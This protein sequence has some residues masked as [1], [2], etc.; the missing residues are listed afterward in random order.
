MSQARIRS[1]LESRLSTWASA[2]NPALQIA[3]ESVPFTPPNSTYIRAFLIPAETES[4][5]LRGLHRGMLG[6]FQI[7][8]VAQEGSGAGH[9]EGIAGEIADLF[10]CDLHL[11]MSPPDFSITLVTPC[12]LGPAQNSDGRY[13][14]PVYFTYRADYFL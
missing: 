9:A 10:P 2:R 5:D 6:V 11:L 1:L 14:I 13:T 3:W 7:D 8:V 4:L 12:S